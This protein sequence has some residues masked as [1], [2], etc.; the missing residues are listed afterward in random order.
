MANESDE[1]RL[2]EVPAT[3]ETGSEPLDED[4]ADPAAQRAE[5]LINDPEP[6]LRQLRLDPTFQ[7]RIGDGFRALRE[8][9]GEFFVASDR[10]ASRTK[11]TAERVIDL[12][13]KELD[14][15]GLS[16]RE[17]LEFLQA[18]ERMANQVG[19]SEKEVRESNERTLTKAITL[20]A[21]AVVGIVV[22]GYLGKD[23]R[24]PP[25]I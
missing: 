18:G 7:S 9:V 20:A 22:L 3:G 21:G 13:E 16:P 24:L 10:G 25:S 17:R 2:D 14:R 5:G 4:I 12:V 1:P 8:G 6:A 23:G 15:E 11:E 19:D